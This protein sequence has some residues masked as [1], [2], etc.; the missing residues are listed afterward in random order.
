VFCS[1]RKTLYS[2]LMGVSADKGSTSVKKMSEASVNIC[3]RC[4]VVTTVSEAHFCRKLRT[5]RKKMMFSAVNSRDAV[6]SIS[7]SMLWSMLDSR[8]CMEALGFNSLLSTTCVP[9]FTDDLERVEVRASVSAD[10]V[11]VDEDA[12]DDRRDCAFHASRRG[13]RMRTC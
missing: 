12:T 5:S 3:R 9:L 2:M 10:F 1:D 7:P 8:A 6:Q 13:M 4:A 11:D